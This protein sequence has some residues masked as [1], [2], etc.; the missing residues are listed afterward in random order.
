MRIWALDLATRTGWASADDAGAHLRSGIVQLRGLGGERFAGLRSWLAHNVQPGDH[1]WIEQPHHRGGPATRI[2]LGL[3]AIAETHAFDV[4]ASVGL[5]HGQTYRAG[6][7][8]KGAKRDKDAWLAY[9]RSRWGE[10]RDDNEAD[11]LILLDW[12][13][14]NRSR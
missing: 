6:L 8:P 5:V 4:S 7:L 11:A 10:V 2:A 13:L 9:A 3:L 14:R 12:V 1:M